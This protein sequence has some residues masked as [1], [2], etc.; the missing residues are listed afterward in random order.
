MLG[1]RIVRLSLLGSE[2]LVL[3]LALR[4]RFSWLALTGIAVG[5]FIVVEALVAVFFALHDGYCV[6]FTS[7]WWKHYG[8]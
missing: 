1:Y 4:R 8:T 3:T 6:P 2:W 5:V 7:C